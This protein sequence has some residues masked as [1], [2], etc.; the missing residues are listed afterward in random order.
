M[1]LWKNECRS[2]FCTIESVLEDN[3]EILELAQKHNA[4]Y[5]LIDDKYEINNTSIFKFPS[6]HTN[7]NL[8]ILDNK[9]KVLF[10]G[11]ALCG[12]IVD[13][14]FIDCKTVLEYQI[15]ILENLTFDIAILSHQ[16]PLTKDEI[17]AKLKEKIKCC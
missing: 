17:I 14:D 7:E 1:F 9:N 8:L 12:K 15:S 10:T 16:S 6:N 4:N 11:D 13:F 5:I 3:A 2:A